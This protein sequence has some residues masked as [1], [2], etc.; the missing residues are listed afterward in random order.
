M[1]GPT[2]P[3][4]RLTNPNGSAE[5]LQADNDRVEGIFTV[6]RGTAYVIGRPREVVVRRVPSNVRVER[7]D[8][9]RAV[10]GHSWSDP[11]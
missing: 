2:L 9:L 10:D 11:G 4:Y 7:V 1:R 5:L 6:L 8:G 3:T